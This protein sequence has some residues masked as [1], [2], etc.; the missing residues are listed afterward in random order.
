[1]YILHGNMRTIINVLKNIIFLGCVFIVIIIGFIKDDSHLDFNKDDSHLDIHSRCLQSGNFTFQDFSL[2]RR[3]FS[4]KFAIFDHI[5]VGDKFRELGEK[6]NITVA[7]QTSFDRLLDITQLSNSWD[8]AMSV[9]IFVADL[10]YSAVK[11]FI[12]YLRVCYPAVRDNI[13]FSFLYPLDHPPVITDFGVNWKDNN[14]LQ[15]TLDPKSL[16]E[17]L[18]K[19]VFTYEYKTWRDPYK[20]PQSHMRNLARETSLTAYTMLLDVDIILT[21]SAALLLSNFLKTE[22][23]KKCEKCIYTFAAYE[24]ERVPTD[25]NDLLKM[26]VDNEAQPFHHTVNKFCQYD[27]NFTAFE[28]SLEKF[29]PR[30]SLPGMSQ[31]VT[32]SH[33]VKNF[34]FLYEPFYLSRNSVPRYDERF[35]GYGFTRNTQTYELFVAGWEFKVISP[36]YLVHLGIKRTKDHSVWRAQQN[37]DN[38]AIYKLF[39]N[40]VQARYKQVDLKIKPTTTMRTKELFLR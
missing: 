27:T 29:D 36:I 38:R 21:D 6:F 16:H 25:K 10:E 22:E 9:A 39:K 28:A 8:G 18:K 4:G 19:R 1:M 24:V 7:T 17:K 2:G 33:S 34:T 20:Y 31:P 32:I 11:I 23:A 40:E 13:A 3:D 15:C 14:F 5:L 26:V 35:L 30:N 37:N 12:E